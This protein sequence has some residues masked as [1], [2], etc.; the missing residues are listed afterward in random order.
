MGA[1]AVI[2][3]EVAGYRYMVIRFDSIEQM[4]HVANESFNYARVV[5]GDV[6]YD[7]VRTNAFNAAFESWAR[8]VGFEYVT[9]HRLN[10][11][12]EDITHR[13]P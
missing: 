6:I 3:D 12:L 7:I 9:A 8:S 13:F 1:Y 5:D 10:V 11:T 4:A 2:T